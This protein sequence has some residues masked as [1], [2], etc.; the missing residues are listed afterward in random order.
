MDPNDDLEPWT[1]SLH[2]KASKAHS[3]VPYVNKLPFSAVAIIV[4]LVSINI[5][6]WIVAIIALVGVI[7]ALFVNCRC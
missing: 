4:L 3:K 5:A 1:K 6:A 7:K 2:R